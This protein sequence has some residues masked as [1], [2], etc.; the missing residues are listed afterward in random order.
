MKSVKIDL[1]DFMEKFLVE[2]SSDPYQEFDIEF[3]E[4]GDDWGHR[5]TV[6][7]NDGLSLKYHYVHSGLAGR[8]S[9]F[10]WTISRGY[11]E[12]VKIIP[13]KRRGNKNTLIR[14]QEY[15]EVLGVANAY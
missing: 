11:S 5:I 7:G 2:N 15:K 1:H 12:V 10:N 13:P 8:E 9:P 3:R 14:V 6:M 4:N